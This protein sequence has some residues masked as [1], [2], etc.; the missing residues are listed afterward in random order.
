MRFRKRIVA[1]VGAMS[2]HAVL[3]EVHGGSHL[4]GAREH[5]GGLYLHEVKIDHWRKRLQRCMAGRVASQ[6][7]L[8]VNKT[9]Q[10]NT[11]T[12]GDVRQAT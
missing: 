8:T 7:Q 3:N 1:I 11:N 2:E 6:K 4:C 10:K 5:S 9:E 12:S